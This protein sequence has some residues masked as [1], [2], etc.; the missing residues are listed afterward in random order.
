[1]VDLIKE[2]DPELLADH[3]FE[4]NYA[5]QPR[6]LSEILE[7][8]HLLFRQVW[9]NRRWNLRGSIEDGAH[10]VVAEKDYSRNP[11]RSDQSLDTV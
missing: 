3:D 10:H 9:Y 7:A 8:E 5:E 4:I 11:Y 2:I 6:R 1:M